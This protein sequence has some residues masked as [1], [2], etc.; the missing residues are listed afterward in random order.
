MTSHICHRPQRAQNTTR[1][2][3]NHSAP[4]TY[5][6]GDSDAFLRDFLLL[7]PSGAAGAGG[8]AWISCSFRGSFTPHISS[9]THTFSLHPARPQSARASARSGPRTAS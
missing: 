5:D 9:S 2:H 4:R 6:T 3:I 8:R 1:T 7:L